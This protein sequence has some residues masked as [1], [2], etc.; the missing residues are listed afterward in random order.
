MECHGGKK[1]NNLCMR[2]LTKTLIED[3]LA[4][5][6]AELG[7]FRGI[8]RAKEQ[9]RRSFKRSSK[10]LATRYEADLL[11]EFKRAKRL[12]LPAYQRRA[13][14]LGKFKG[15]LPRYRSYD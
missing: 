1:S 10:A 5:F 14:N 11:S 2:T 6:S 8:G 15:V 12:A 9:A 3:L 13:K 7:P 4:A